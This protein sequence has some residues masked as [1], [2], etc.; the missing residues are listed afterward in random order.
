M[1]PET[2]EKATRRGYKRENHTSHIF[3]EVSSHEGS[4]AQ[5]QLQPQGLHL[6]RPDGGGQGPKQSGH[7]LRDRAA[8]RRPR[9]GL[10]RLQPVQQERLRIHR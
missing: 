7:R 10:H 9:P 1:P 2:K 4:N 6:Y 8:G 3:K 5:R